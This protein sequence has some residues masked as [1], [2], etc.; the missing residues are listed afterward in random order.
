[1]RALLP[2]PVDDVDIHAYYGAGWL[3]R[4]G[5][6]VNFVGSVDGGSSANGTSRGLQTTGDNQVFAALRDL[7][8]VVLVGAGTAVAEGY[9]PINPSSQR[10]AG[11]RARGLREVPPV[12]VL[13]RSLRLDP[14]TP[15][16]AE[17]QP[18]ART[19][20][21]TCEAADAEVRRKLKQVAEVVDCG[22]DT[23]D[24]A[25]VRAALEER[26]LTRILCEG[27]PSVF[28]DLARDGVVD[29]LCLSVSP[30]LA[31]PG[32]GRIVSGDAWDAPADLALVGLLE[33]DGAL[34]CRYR[35]TA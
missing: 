11:R 4:G 5:V 34:F 25:L 16:F 21:L 28:A 9:G 20:V 19:L 24:G 22:D 13:S 18:T 14:D 17:A 10:R 30:M 33:D 15:L 3:D 7:A 23:V 32:P 26:G 35:L 1:M 31:G 29:E 27:G 6:R 8:D 2:G 12:A